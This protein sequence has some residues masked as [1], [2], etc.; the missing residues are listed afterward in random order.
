[1]CKKDKIHNNT[2]AITIQYPL[3]YTI[4][5]GYRINI[6]MQYTENIHLVQV[7]YKHE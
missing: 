5:Y 1:M 6:N 2:Q 4:Q 7:H 3:Q